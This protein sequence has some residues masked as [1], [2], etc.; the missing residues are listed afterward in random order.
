[1]KGIAN[2]CLLTKRNVIFVLLLAVEV[3]VLLAA[4]IGRLEAGVGMVTLMLYYATICI[5]ML[6]ADEYVNHRHH[7]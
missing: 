3:T 5:W 2:G 7:K 4:A 1:M 6:T